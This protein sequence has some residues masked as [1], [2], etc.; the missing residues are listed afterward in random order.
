M[1]LRSMPGAF[2]DLDITRRLADFV[3]GSSADLVSRTVPAVVS[4][5][6]LTDVLRR[7]VD[8]EIGVGDLAGIL[9]ALA[10]AGPGP[11]DTVALTEHAR[12][13]LRSHITAR[14]ARGQD[15]LRVITVSQDVEAAIASAIERTSAGPYLHLAPDI[16]DS[17]L[18]A[19]RET[20][21]ALGERAEG[22]PLL[23]ESA[24]V[25][26]FVRR[27]V[28]LEWPSLHVLSRRDLLP[29]QAI[30]QVGLI[31]LDRAMSAA[32]PGEASA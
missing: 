26:P 25:R 9:E 13:A 29:D 7:L 21:S 2:L 31:R 23:V 28:S 6:E 27:L 15:R 24:D 8:E 18:V 1:L 17:L 30:E 12:Q 14:F 19:I 16:V 20:I 10:K 5:F 11:H 22:A 3:E 4:W 32:D